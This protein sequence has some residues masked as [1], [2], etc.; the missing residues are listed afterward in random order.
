[1]ALGLLILINFPSQ[2]SVRDGEEAGRL[3]R[4]LSPRLAPSDLVILPGNGILFFGTMPRYYYGVDVITLDVL[5][6]QDDPA[7]W[8]GAKGDEVRQ[9]GHKVWLLLDYAE[10]TSERVIQ[11]EQVRFDKGMG[12]VQQAFVL[13]PKA[14]FDDPAMK[15][16]WIAQCLPRQ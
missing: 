8:L 2:Y 12:A 7:G 10:W 5:E 15:E 16:A 11:G 4:W 3:C 6:K 1:M 13:G 14:E 9:Q